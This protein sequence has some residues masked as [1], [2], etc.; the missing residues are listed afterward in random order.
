MKKRIFRSIVVVALAVLL[1]CIFIFIGVLYNYFESVQKSDLA[2]HINFVAQGVTNEGINYFD[3][4]KTGVYRITWVDK[5]G[6]VLYDSKEDAATMENHANRPEIKSAYETGYGES[7]RYS[8]TLME[9]LIYVAERLND[10]TV[11]RVSTLQDTFPIYLMIL[12]KPIVVVLIVSILISLLLASRLTK[13]IIKPF[14]TLNLDEPL[15]NEVYD[16]LAPLLN[17]IEK[18]Q[19]QIREQLVK[20]KHNQEE[21]ATV[22]GNMNE[23]L[24]LFNDKGMI[25]S[26]NN[27]A[28]TLFGTNQNCIG[29]D[30]LTVNRSIEMRGI[31]NQALTG[32]HAE[33]IMQLKGGEYQIAA[34]PIFSGEQI[35][36]GALLV[37]DI[38]ERRNSEQMRREFTANV[39]HELKTPL[40]SISGCAEIIKGGLVKP[41]DLPQFINQIYAESQRMSA[42]IEDILLLSRLDEQKMNLTR[43]QVDLFALANKVVGKLTQT[44]SDNK[45]KII[46]SGEEAIIDGVP[47]LIEE[48]I[49]NL[50]ENAIKYNRENGRV[51]ITVATNENTAMLG[52]ADTGIG[53]PKADQARIFERFYRVDKSHSKKTGG[54]GL[55]LSIV[56]HA[57]QLHNAT[58]ELNSE[59]G[60]GTTI[61]VKFPK[62]DSTDSQN[63]AG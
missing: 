4:L 25:I 37:Y 17:R 29:N 10:G 19:R 8:S 63:T 35:V 30:I 46:L 62:S 59:L 7:V 61:C 60:Q 23:G 2:A 12:I 58:I 22:T 55:G 24:V 31:L 26:I 6:T 49:S 33:T 53:I 39:S 44:A 9:R 16:E 48:I 38:S 27:S 14:N 20:L 51:N 36:G 32:E 54:T 1:A 5:D 18:Q 47:Q 21:F 3:G 34:N 43:E 50:C 40:H 45:V 56:K 11:I 28:A 52:V 41:E 42:L 15:T 57:A 13:R